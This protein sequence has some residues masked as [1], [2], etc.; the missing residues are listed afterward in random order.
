MSEKQDSETGKIYLFVRWEDEHGQI[1]FDWHTGAEIAPYKRLEWNSPE[2]DEFR[3][4]ARW[5]PDGLE[6]YRD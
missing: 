3:R 2:M 6:R 5:N 1:C 4:E